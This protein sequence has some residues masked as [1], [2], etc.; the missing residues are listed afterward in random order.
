MG[1]AKL[2]HSKVM[3]DDSEQL[4]RDSTWFWRWLVARY[5][6]ANRR[7]ATSF[8][9]TNACFEPSHCIFVM[10][11]AVIL[12][13]ALFVDVTALRGTVRALLG[14]VICHLS[15]PRLAVYLN[16]LCTHT[17]VT[18]KR[19][20][21]AHLRSGTGFVYRYIICP[22]RSKV[23][24]ALLAGVCTSAVQCSRGKVFTSK[25]GSPGI[26]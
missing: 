7:A 19:R 16:P 4:L 3:M 5:I 6:P 9:R 11:Q 18:L 20:Q 22:C 17:Q 8:A 13:S 14:A 24:K 25:Q 2:M 1:Q 15:V 23:V 10:M 12:I 21:I 26:L